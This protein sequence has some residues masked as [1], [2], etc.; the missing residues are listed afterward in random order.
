MSVFRNSVLGIT[1]ALVLMGAGLPKKSKADELQVA[2]KTFYSHVSKLSADGTNAL[3]FAFGFMNIH[4][5]NLC[6]I[7]SVRIS[8]QKQ[9]I[10]IEVS[11]EYRFTLPS[12]KAL[13]IADAVVILDLTEPSN[14]C[15]ISVQLE[16]KTEYVKASYTIEELNLL[17]QQ[18]VAFFDD[19]GGFMSFMMPKVDGL[20]IQFKDKALS[21]SLTNGMQIENGLLVIDASDLAK[22]DQ[23]SLPSMPLRI[24]AKTTK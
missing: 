21:S 5:K 15:D 14:T 10:P 16:T 23:I 4:T 1:L 20:T 19:I 18:Y 12:E 22:L 6:Q 8:T 17:Y 2:Y 11:P 24:T 13:R 7:N 3:Q 9:Q